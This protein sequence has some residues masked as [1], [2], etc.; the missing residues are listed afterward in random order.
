MKRTILVLMATFCVGISAYAIG[1][2]AH[3][4]VDV[5]AWVT[6][7]SAFDNDSQS[8]PKGSEDDSTVRVALD[9]IFGGLLYDF[10]YRMFQNGSG[11]NLK[12]DGDLKNDQKVDASLEIFN[13]QFRTLRRAFFHGSDLTRF[14]WNYDSVPFPSLR[15]IICPTATVTSESFPNN[16]LMNGL[17]GRL[18]FK[19]G[20][21]G[22]VSEMEGVVV[23]NI[24]LRDIGDAQH[25]SSNAPNFRGMSFSASG[26]GDSE[27]EFNV[28]M[29]SDYLGSLNLSIDQVKMYADGVEF[30]GKCKCGKDRGLAL[31]KGNRFWTTIC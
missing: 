22:D 2:R 29:T 18:E 1:Y 16:E 17:A 7:D 20:G 13:K 19:N 27:V 14:I 28:Y 31:A 26:V 11:L 5:T 23:T 9:P 12:Q 8:D 4:V 6:D 25:E 21:T 10:E 3:A 15:Y 24:S 30:P